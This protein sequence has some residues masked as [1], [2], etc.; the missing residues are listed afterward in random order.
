MSKKP[1][2]P[3]HVLKT[4]QTVKCHVR[5]GKEREVALSAKRGRMDVDKVTSQF[6]T[7]M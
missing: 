7:Q 2:P 6:N 3:H 5:Y 1:K 4:L